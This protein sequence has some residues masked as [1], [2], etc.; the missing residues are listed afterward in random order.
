MVYWNAK[1]CSEIACTRLLNP[2]SPVIEEG[3]IEYYDTNF[4]NEF[5]HE[6][7]YRGPPTPERE[8]AWD[9]LW[10]RGAAE[11]PV[12]GVT[13]LN[14]SNA[15]L[16]HVHFDQSRGYVSMLEAFHQLHLEPYSPIY[17]E[18]LLR[19][20]YARVVTCTRT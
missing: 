18:R 6:T 5:A 7:K 17:M 14:K 16:K 10:N 20:A 9:K 3:I 11:V 19:R 4:E 13:K 15:R 8:E 12:E 1:S 2:Y